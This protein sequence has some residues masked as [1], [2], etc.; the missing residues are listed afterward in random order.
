M[1]GLPKR[2]S[3]FFY[4]DGKLEWGM[5]ADVV[6]PYSTWPGAKGGLGRGCSPQIPGV[7]V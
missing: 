3:L 2:A 5:T 1:R 4:L 7:R 6:I